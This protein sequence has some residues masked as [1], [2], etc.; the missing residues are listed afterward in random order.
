[1][2]KNCK[3]CGKEFKTYPSK[4]SIGRGKFC[5]VECSRK[6]T[7]KN[8]THRWVKGIRHSRHKHRNLKF[9][10]YIEIYKPNHPNYTQRGYVLEHRLIVE[11]YIGRYLEKFEDVHHINGI[12]NDNRIDNLKI[13][14]HSEHTRINN[15]VSFRWARKGG[16]AQ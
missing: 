15:P 11:K 4:V 1:M 7:N 16:D 3:Q 12:K 14:T 5:S 2:I 10:G 13:L 8:L 6:V 9:N